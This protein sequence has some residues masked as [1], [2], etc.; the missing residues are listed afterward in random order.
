MKGNLPLVSICIPV[1]NS[2]NTIG[3]TLSSIVHQTY[4]N[5]EIIVVDN[6]SSD[7]TV[8]VIEEF[9]DSRIKL[10]KNN[11]FLPSAEQNWNRCFQYVRGEFMALFHAD[12]IYFPNIVARQI[13]T[14]YQNEFIGGVF[15]LGNKIDDDD[16]LIGTFSLPRDMTDDLNFSYL[17]LLSRVMTF[18]DF[19]IC[20]TAMIKTQIYI[21]MAPF[22]NEL[23]FSAS[24][25]DMWLRAAE[26]S[27]IMIINE[28]LI[29]YRLSK[30]QGTFRLN[31]LRTK[32][33][34]FFKVLDY[35]LSK[36]RNT[37]E[38]PEY[39]SK[40]Y[41]IHRL[42]DSLL[43]AR[44]YLIK[45]EPKK[46]WHLMKEIPWIEDLLIIL[47]KPCLFKLIFGDLYRLVGTCLIY[48]I[49]QNHSLKIY[50]KFKKIFL[51]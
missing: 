7:R 46:F 3:K 34:D 5:I 13:E 49:F 27:P 18:G 45:L 23:F 4:S 25:L 48:F 39:A 35:H 32:E 28:N 36:V 9:N 16:K 14:F 15:C 19:L 29:N 43:R 2:Q 38:I 11:T 42:N 24:D 10:I 20:P 51:N 50:H 22:R 1:Y 41:N 40:L 44:N 31:H 47:K 37:V 8:Q 6:C 33:A 30:N 17:K 12:D 21:K 26:I